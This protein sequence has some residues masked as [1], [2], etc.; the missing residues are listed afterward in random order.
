MKSTLAVLAAFV[1]AS[2][3]ANVDIPMAAIVARQESP[4][5]THTVKALNPACKSVLVTMPTP[6]PALI[7]EVKSQFMSRKI[8]NP[9]DFSTPAS[10]KDQ[11]ASYTSAVSVWGGENKDKIT[12]AC[13]KM[14]RFLEFTACDKQAGAEPTKA[15]E[16]VGGASPVVNKA[17]AATGMNME[18]KHTEGMNMEGQHTEGMNMNM[19]MGDDKSKK[20]DASR[21]SG[22]AMTAFAVAAAGLVLA[23]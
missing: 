14:P 12:G 10:L 11:V 18:G 15:A 23:L 21:Q 16:A 2:S 13:S 4:N 17:A 1:A 3:A 6:P 8:K 19:N 9:C 5:P 20:N 22:M 7:S